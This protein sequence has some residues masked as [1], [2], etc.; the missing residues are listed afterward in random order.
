MHPPGSNSHLQ[1][2]LR[3]ITKTLAFEYC[4]HTYTDTRIYL[5]IRNV[6]LTCTLILNIKYVLAGHHR[7]TGKATIYI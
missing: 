7:M 2:C 1:E 6:D 3:H 5:M 4:S